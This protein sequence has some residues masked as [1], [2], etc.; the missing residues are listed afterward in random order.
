MA[1]IGQPFKVPS[2][3]RSLATSFAMAVEGQL[4]LSFNINFLKLL[5]SDILLQDI[6]GRTV[7]NYQCAW[8]TND[9]PTDLDLADIMDYSTLTKCLNT[10]IDEVRVLVGNNSV[11]VSMALALEEVWE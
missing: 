10:H 3:L 9:K 1:A 7:E 2:L 5:N 11:P 6:I 8:W 4:P